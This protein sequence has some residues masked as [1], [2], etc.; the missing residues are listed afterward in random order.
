[1]NV[2]SLNYDEL[3]IYQEEQVCDKFGIMAQPYIILFVSMFIQYT[4]EVLLARFDIKYKIWF[5]KNK[6][7]N[8]PTNYCSFLKSCCKPN[9]NKYDTNILNHDDLVYYGKNKKPSYGR[10][11]NVKDINVLIDLDNCEHIKKKMSKEYAEKVLNSCVISN[12][13]YNPKFSSN[14]KKS[15]CDFSNVFNFFSISYLIY[16]TFSIF[17]QVINILVSFK[18]SGKPWINFN[19]ILFLIFNGSGYRTFIGII[20][21]N[22]A[23]P[24]IDFYL[25]YLRID[26]VLSNPYTFLDFY[27]ISKP[28]LEEKKYFKTFEELEKY[29]LTT[30]PK[31]K[32]NDEFKEF[33]KYYYIRRDRLYLGSSVTDNTLIRSI[34]YIDDLI[35]E[36]PYFT[37]N[38]LIIDKVKYLDR[39]NGLPR[40]KKILIGLLFTLL[41]PF[42]LSGIFIFSIPIFFIYIWI[43]FI[44]AFLYVTIIAFIFKFKANGK[45]NEEKTFL[46]FN[47]STNFLKRFILLGFLIIFFNYGVIF[48]N[49]KGY[50]ETY[51]LERKS[52]D[53]TVYLNCMVFDKLQNTID[54]LLT[55]T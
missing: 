14:E 28:P 4:I 24:F 45:T 9:K 43:F 27:Y 38:N 11:Y 18:Y 41:L 52:R 53:M 26:S 2:S 19:N 1:M 3:F 47:Y 49:G 51:N 23:F 31:A 5:W 17:Y 39:I 32:F 29:I 21:A 50:E 37:K 36:N 16:Q 12:S 10:N 42:M 55:Y 13:L 8:K 33:E 25:N 6:L 30:K 15:C 44:I 35:R 7:S 54:F 40:K 34:D 20:C 48:Y 22:I 46:F